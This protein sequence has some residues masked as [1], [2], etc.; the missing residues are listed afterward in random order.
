MRNHFCCAYIVKAYVLTLLGLLIAIFANAQAKADDQSVLKLLVSKGTFIVVK[1]INPKSFKDHWLIPDDTVSHA[2][3]RYGYRAFKETGIDIK[4]LGEIIANSHNVDTTLWTVQE[5]GR[6]ILINQRDSFLKPQEVLTTLNISDEVEVKN[7]RKTI[8]RFDNTTS[9]NRYI[10]R[11]SRPVFDNAGRYAAVLEDFG[12]AG[13]SGGGV[14]IVFE[15]KAD[16]WYR[17]GTPKRWAY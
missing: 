15:K 1:P 9:E 6:V 12:A 14:V 4:S 16:G 13:M 10:Y 2:D 8:R 11:S 7:Y 3:N 17:V 5:L